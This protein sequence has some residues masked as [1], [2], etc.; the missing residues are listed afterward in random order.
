M[1][2]REYPDIS[3]QSR[4]K[5]HKV[6]ARFIVINAIIDKRQQRASKIHSNLDEDPTLKSI[7]CSGVECR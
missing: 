3:F 7:F 4:E 2:K 1:G 6:R 5:R